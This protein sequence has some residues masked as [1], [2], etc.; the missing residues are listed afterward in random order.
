MRGKINVAGKGEQTDYEI[1][2]IRA[3]YEKGSLKVEIESI[4]PRG[5][6]KYGDTRVTVR[7]S[8][9]AE[10]TDAYPEPKCKFGSNQRIVDAIYIK[11]TTKPPSF[12]AKDSIRGTENKQEVNDTCI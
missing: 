6:P 7:A 1:D 10:L 12:Y 4:S 9:L 11:C 2:D 5:G 8:G 3:R